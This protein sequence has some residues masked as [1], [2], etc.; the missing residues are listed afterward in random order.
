VNEVKNRLDISDMQDI[1]RDNQRLFEKLIEDLEKEKSSGRSSATQPQ[2]KRMRPY[3][4]KGLPK[5]TN[6]KKG[7]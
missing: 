1:F 2:Q 3:E 6:L 7:V 5:V 4:V